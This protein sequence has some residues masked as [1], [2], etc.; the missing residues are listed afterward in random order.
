MNIAVSMTKANR[1]E[2]KKKHEDAA[3]IYGDILAKFPQNARAQAALASLQKKI[4]QDLNP[5][6]LQAPAPPFS[7]RTNGPPFSG[8]SLV[9]AISSQ[10][11]WM[12]QQPF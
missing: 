8:P 7:P 1:L 9:N 5:P 6:L 3:K 11:I 12:R 4:A 10:K 2:R